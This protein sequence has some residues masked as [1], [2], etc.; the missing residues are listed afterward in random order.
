MLCLAYRNWVWADLMTVTPW[1]S[2]Y[3]RNHCGINFATA[4][5]YWTPDGSDWQSHLFSG[6]QHRS[7]AGLC[8]QPPPLNSVQHWLQSHAHRK[9]HSLE[10]TTIIG[11]ITNN[12][13]SSYPEEINSLAKWWTEKNLTLKV[14]KT[15]RLISDFRKREAQDIHLFLQLQRS[16]W[17][18]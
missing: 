5:G 4:T 13:E 16:S 2:Q 1:Q 10:N 15:I 7:P 8:A 17:I 9:L 14:S 12:S 3:T 18:V 6:A 11:W